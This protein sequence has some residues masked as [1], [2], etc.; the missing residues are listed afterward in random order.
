MTIQERPWLIAIDLEGA[1]GIP[2]F[3]QGVYAIQDQADVAQAFLALPL[4]KRLC[5]LG[6][7]LMKD[8]E[9]AAPSESSE[10]ADSKDT[11]GE[12]D[13]V[14]KKHNPVVSIPV[15]FWQ[16][17]WKENGHPLLLLPRGRKDAVLT[18][19]QKEKANITFVPLAPVPANLAALLRPYPNPKRLNNPEQAEFLK[20]DPKQVAALAKALNQQRDGVLEYPMGGGKSLLIATILKAYPDLRP[21]V[22]TSASSP[23]SQ[24]LAASLA[25]MTGEKTKLLGC[26]SGKL[27]RQQKTALF[28]R[29]T[30]GPEIYVSTHNIFANKAREQDDDIIRNHAKL[31]ILDEIHEACTVRR[32]TGLIKTSPVKAFGTTATWLKNWNQGDRVMADLIA[33]TRTPLVQVHHKDV[34]ESGRIT[35]MEIHCY[36]LDRASFNHDRPG[37]RG[38]GLMQNEVE[39]HDGRNRFVAHLCNHLMNLNAREN[40]G[41]I[42]AFAK[43]IGHARRIVRELCAIRGID[44]A[45][46]HGLYYEQIAVFN[47]QLPEQEKIRK[48]AELEARRT[49]IVFSTDT[50]ARGIDYACIHDTVDC[51]GHLQVA[52]TI[53]KSGRSVRTD[54]EGKIARMHMVIDDQTQ[55]ALRVIS[56]K[57]KEALEKYYAAPAIMHRSEELP[58]A[59][60]RLPTPPADD[61]EQRRKFAAILGLRTPD[62]A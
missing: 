1:P 16:L 59:V 60:R 50:L 7:Y 34:E 28:A 57:K 44:Y 19:L 11:S 23:D 31:I 2:A 33:T 26:A 21:A 24:Q 29:K 53:Q 52:L 3:T 4:V 5:G 32:M 36:D 15:P 41:V 51:S 13:A 18:L 45:D 6:T 61:T 38:F 62:A 47:A 56:Y 48:L 22:V 8:Y 55:E 46:E 54:G 39:F 35:P 25:I 20:L 30:A 58:W 42:L 40:R 17:D 49:S 14:H 37:Y 43:T 12:N 10:D 27:T 9:E